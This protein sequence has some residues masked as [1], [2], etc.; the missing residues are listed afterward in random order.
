MCASPQYSVTWDS[1]LLMESEMKIIRAIWRYIF[2][3]KNDPRMVRLAWA[4]QSRD[5][6]TATDLYEELTK[7]YQSLMVGHYLKQQTK[8]RELR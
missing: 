5:Y 7:E 3:A 2:G 4:V 1:F 8:E 6:F